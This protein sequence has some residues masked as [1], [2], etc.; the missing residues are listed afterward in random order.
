MFLS[1]LLSAISVSQNRMVV[2]SIRL[3]PKYILGYESVP[4]DEAKVRADYI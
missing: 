3:D 4:R 1:E 2:Y